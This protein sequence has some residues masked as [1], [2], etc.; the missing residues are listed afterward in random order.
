MANLFF[1]VDDTFDFYKE[2]ILFVNHMNLLKSMSVQ[3]S[4][5]YKKWIECKSLSDRYDS[6]VNTK[7][8]IWEPADIKDYN[9]TVSEINNLVPIIELVESDYDDME[10]FNLRVFSHSMSFEQN[11]GRFL[12]FIVKDKNTNKYLGIISL[13][14]DVTSISSRDKYI[15]WTDVHKFDD[16][17]LR[18]T[19]IATCIMSTQPFGFNFLGGKL[20]ASLIS[21][22]HVRNIWKEKYNDIL[23]GVTTTSLYGQGSMYNGI[24]YWKSLGE[25]AG[26][27]LIKPDDDMYNIWHKWYKENKPT[28]YDRI[29]TKTTDSAGPVTGIKQRILYAIFKELNIKPTEFVHGY[30]RGVYFM[31]FY[32]NFKEYLTSKIDDTELILNNKFTDDIDGIIK[33]WKTKSINRYTKL[34]QT[35]R[36]N[37]ELL[38]YN[39]LPFLSWNETKSKYITDVGR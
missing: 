16:G 13:S 8:N 22:K 9:R 37:S 36:L 34:F 3:E 28:E 15:G 19:S 20:I 11:P 25:S 31:P 10:W 17:K 27:V 21:T 18:N 2:R 24:P 35:N 6:S 38:Y 4:T 30:K 12:K 32:T 39:K 33:W 29:T 5:L 14:S 26:K 1:D 23:I 7:F